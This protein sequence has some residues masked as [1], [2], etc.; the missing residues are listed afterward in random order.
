[1]E[2]VLIIGSPG[3]GKSTLAR[4]LARKTS[5]PLI[6]LDQEYWSPGWVEPD[7]ADWSR[8]LTH[9]LNRPQW[10]I[11][12]NYGRT[13]TQRAAAADAIVFLDMPRTLCLWRCLNR[14]LRGY[15]KTRDDMPAGCPERFDIDF[16]Q[17][18]W[19]FNKRNRAEIL[20]LLDT[21]AGDVFALH[22]SDEVEGFLRRP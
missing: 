17:Y 16:L 9:L 21:F 3:S 14:I 10:I 4:T 2:R 18:V 19:T 5:L 12:G 20:T 1:V 6:H 7:F 15:G 11:D 13:L 22:N 8:K